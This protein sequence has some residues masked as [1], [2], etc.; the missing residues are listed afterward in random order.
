M[1]AFPQQNAHT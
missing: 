1:L